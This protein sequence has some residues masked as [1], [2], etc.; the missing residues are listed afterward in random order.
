VS[1]GL[2]SSGAAGALA[3][4]GETLVAVDG[5][6]PGIEA[7]LATLRQVLGNPGLGR[8]LRDLMRGERRDV[9][10]VAHG[11]GIAAVDEDRRAIGQHDG[12]AGRAAE[13]GEPSQALGAAGHVFALMLVGARDHEAVDA[14]AREFGAQQRQALRRRRCRVEAVAGRDKLC[15][16][17]G[18]SLGQFGIGIGGDQFDPF[19][20]CQPLRGGGH[21]A[22]Q[23]GQGGGVGLAATLAQEL[24]D[25]VW[26]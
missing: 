10:L 12:K 21:A 23:G 8:F 24:E 5:L 9:D 16:P 14:A 11:Q 19:R 2:E 3:G 20:A 13:A 25:V 7:E 6:Q 1:I 18:Q 22:H 17:R 26:G 4:A 15:P